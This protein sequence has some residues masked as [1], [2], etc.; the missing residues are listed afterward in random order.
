[1]RSGLLKEA[2]TV[3]HRIYTEDEFGASSVTWQEDSETIWARKTYKDSGFGMQDG[4]A[5]YKSVVSFEMRYTT[6]VKPYDRIKWA[7]LYWR[8][9]GFEPYPDEG[10]L[11]LKCE[12]LNQDE[13]KNTTEQ[14]TTQDKSGQTS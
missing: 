6:I 9:V 10:R 3:V 13:W 4:E 1:M 11:V 7:S 5:V 14:D 8:I 2:L 12:L